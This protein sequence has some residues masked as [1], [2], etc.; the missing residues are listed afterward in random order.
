MQRTPKRFD[1]A[2]SSYGALG[3]LPDIRAWARGV[4]RVLRPGGKLVY[5]EFH[6][7]VWSFDET[8]PFGLTGDDYFQTQPFNEPVG[9]YVESSGVA[10]GAVDVVPGDPNTI[11]AM[12]YQHTLA[13]IV[14]A[15]IDA[16][17]QVRRL[18][19]WPYANGCRVKEGLVDIGERRWGWP[20]ETTAP[21]MFALVAER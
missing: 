6:P 16:G 11:P 21:L 18:S 20:G 13:D 8:A 17:L 3:W 1:V 19:E 4:H 7:L 2:F 14:Q 5:V 10:L 15:V 12:S 9:D